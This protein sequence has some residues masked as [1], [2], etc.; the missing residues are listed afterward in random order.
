MMALIKYNIVHF[1][2][3]NFF[4]ENVEQNILEIFLYLHFFQ[5]F[6]RMKNWQ[7]LVSKI[8]DRYLDFR[9]KFYIKLKE[10]FLLSKSVFK[11]TG[12]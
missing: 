9:T 3:G 5:R 8:T 11:T 4:T 10:S 6:L 2:G 1:I 12:K 7:S